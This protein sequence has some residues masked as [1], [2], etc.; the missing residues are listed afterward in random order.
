MYD[1]DGSYNRVQFWSLVTEE[2]IRT[3]A[4]NRP[5]PPSSVAH[6]PRDVIF[7]GIVAARPRHQRRNLVRERLQQLCP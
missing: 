6:P 2:I 1:K 5:Q 3:E 7:L 4:A